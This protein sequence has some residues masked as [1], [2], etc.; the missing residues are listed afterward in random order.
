VLKEVDGL[1]AVELDPHDVTLAKATATARLALDLE[2]SRQIVATVTPAALYGDTPE[3]VLT[4][5]RD[6]WQV[7]IADARRV[8]AAYLPADKMRIVLVGD[9]AKI[10][11][12]TAGLGDVEVLRPR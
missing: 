10:K 9:G 2:T 3:K 11:E 4:R 12:A 7:P 5:R 6:G 8:A 1:R